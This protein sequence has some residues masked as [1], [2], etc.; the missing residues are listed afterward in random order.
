M[1]K[2]TSDE[3]L[4]KLIEGAGTVK[5]GQKIGLKQKGKRIF[6]LKLNF[7]LSLSLQNINKGLF[8]I[9]GLL[10]LL[11]LYT[12]VSG[13]NVIRADLIFPSSKGSLG[14]SKL[15]TQE[16]QF[17]RLQEYANEISKRNIFLASDIR[18]NAKKELTPDISQLIQDLKLVGIIW[19][20]NPEVMIES[21]KENRTYLLK[22]GETFSQ[23]QIKIKD[24]T[25]SSAVLEMEVEGKIEEYELR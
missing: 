10:T 13:A 1:N 12:I 11:F 8:V 23:P 9:C 14:I 3:K 18:A 15:V 5:P 21:T 6:P 17:L 7:R 2:E 4:L 16:S 25:R 19:S 22:K 20:S 24:I